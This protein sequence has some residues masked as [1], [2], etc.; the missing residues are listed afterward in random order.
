[1]GVCMTDLPEPFTV[2]HGLRC[3]W[4]VWGEGDQLGTLNLLTAQRKLDAVKE[5]KEGHSI[6]LD[7]P[8]QFPAQPL[9]AR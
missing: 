5:I 8:L 2:V 6:C 4:Q 3:A 7:L 1:M 9:F